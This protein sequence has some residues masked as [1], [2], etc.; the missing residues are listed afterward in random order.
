ML[1][2]GIRV[3]DVTSLHLMPDNPRQV[4]ATISIDAATPI[5]ADTLVSLEFQGLTGYAVLTLSGGSERGAAPSV[6]PGGGYPLLNAAEGAG[7]S[8]E[9][10]ARRVLARLDKILVENETDV[11]NIVSNVSSFADLLGRNT[12]RVDNIVAGLE[13]M[14]AAGKGNGVFYSLNAIAAPANPAPL[15]KQVAVADPTALMAYDFEKLLSQNP[16]GQIEPIG[17]AKWTD[18]VPKLMQAKIIQS[19]EAAGALGEVNRP[20]DGS[21]PDFQLV[22]EIRRFQIVQAPQLQA[23]AEL[24]VKFV[25]N[26]GRV[27]ASRIFTATEPVQSKDDTAEAARALNVAFGS[28]ETGLV[29][30]VREL[31]VS[32]AAAAAEVKE[33]PQPQAE[34]EVPAIKE[35]KENSKEGKETKENNKEDKEGKDTKENKEG[36][37][38]K[39]STHSHNKSPF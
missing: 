25:S 20:N 34:A 35:T 21:T 14:T 26:D 18:T 32:A 22:T 33:Q 2:N 15:G 23:E 16:S 12:G 10:S 36:K 13:R 37:D 31:I 11:R 24:S 38:R 27:V 4:E 3:G 9:Q 8:D 7:E 39:H 29:G 28:I 30:W 17:N 6:P 5:R 1:F 19:F